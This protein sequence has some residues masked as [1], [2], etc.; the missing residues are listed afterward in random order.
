MKLWLTL[1][2]L[3]AIFM[4]GG[5]VGLNPYVGIPLLLCGVATT[6]WLLW[7]RSRSSGGRIRARTWALAG[8]ALSVLLALSALHVVNPLIVFAVLVFV[9]VVI[10]AQQVRALVGPKRSNTLRTVL[11]RGALLALIGLLVAVGA[12]R[13]WNDRQRSNPDTYDMSLA[14]LNVAYHDQP[15]LVDTSG[16]LPERGPQIGGCGV[17]IDAATYVRLEHVIASYHKVGGGMS[18]QMTLD[19]SGGPSKREMVP[20]GAAAGHYVALPGY[21]YPP[22]LPDTFLPLSDKQMAARYRE[23][24]AYIKQHSTMFG[25]TARAWGKGDYAI[26]R[27]GPNTAY[28][29]G[30]MDQPADS[31]YLTA[32]HLGFQGLFS[33]VALYIL[34]APFAA[35][36]AW[37]LN[38]RIVRPVTQV[39]TASVALADGGHPGPI[40]ES[41]PAELATMA[42]SFNRMS[43]KLEQAKTAE[44]EF[45]LSVG[46]ELK[47]PLTA[48][49]GYAEL[50]A[51][52]DVPAKEATGV[53]G[54]ESRRLKRLIADLMD[55]GR[56]RQ[57]TFAVQRETVDLANIA[58]E[59]VRRYAPQARQY[60]VEL[61]KAIEPE[62]SRDLEA[63]GD[64]D[65]LVQA[66]SNLV[67][68]ALRYTPSQGQVTIVVESGRLTVRDTGP[69][70][71][72][73]DLRP[74]LRTLLS[75][76]TCAEGQARWNRSWPC[77]C[78]TARRGD[79]RL[80]H[81]QEHGGRRF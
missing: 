79:G 66:L 42:A 76:R 11:F 62:D 21:Q 75:L 57:S 44:K 35:L 49:E 7:D 40:P 69:G 5:L 53:I 14:W 47:T 68:N 38:R 28:F 24:G 13:W 64:E 22:F 45:L 58:A 43:T 1:A 77:H 73:A 55:L 31:W 17:W 59:V 16:T 36:C 61:R 26:W 9:V 4:G 67:E 54:A 15:V 70:L 60:G 25:P 37:Y 23:L 50:L 80:R 12:L 34:L 39:A 8:L 46:H 3:A 56:M 10:I 41:G 65:R 32:L 63:C 52:G 27:T 20:R 48:I 2:A 81:R 18:G 19:G 51:D 33:A 72:K 71:P 30:F 74:C 78:E 6:G 29:V